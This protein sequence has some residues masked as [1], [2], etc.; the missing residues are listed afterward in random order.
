M[1]STGGV[2]VIEF[3]NEYVL[4]LPHLKDRKSPLATN[5]ALCFAFKSCRPEWKKVPSSVPSFT[6]TGNKSET[7]TK[8]M[9]ETGHERA[10][11]SGGVEFLLISQPCLRPDG[12]CAP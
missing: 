3:Y 12:C 10:C 2:I 4:S 9:R 6:V 1:A 5:K 7:S 11:C 8:A